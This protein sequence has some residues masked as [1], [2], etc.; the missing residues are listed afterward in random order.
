MAASWDEIR[1]LAADLQHAQLSSTVQRLSD[2]NCIEIVNK[3]VELRLLE[4]VFTCDGKEYVTPQHII[5]EIKDELLIHGGRI[6]LVDLAQLLNLDFSHIEAKAND[7]VRSDKTL[8]LVL[9]QIISRNYLD[10]IAEEINERLQQSGQISIGEL[11]KHYDLP[12]Q[13]LKDSIEERLGTSIQGKADPYDNQIIFTEIFINRLRSRILGALSAATVP[14]SVLNLVNHHNFHERF[15]HSITND[16]ISNGLLAGSIS[17][18]RQERAIYIPTIYS[19]AQ[20]EWVENFYRQNGYLEFD[21]LIR[22]GISEPVK[23]IKKIFSDQSLTYLSTCVVGQS[24]VDQ[25]DASVDEALVSGTWVD[26]MPILPTVCDSDDARQLLLKNMKDRSHRSYSGQIFCDTIVCSDKFIQEL[27]KSF[28]VL[29][30]QKAEKDAQKG[31]SLV[32]KD[33]KGGGEGLS[34]KDKKDERRKK[35]A[36][37]KSG[38]G[39]QGRETKTRAVKKKYRSR[40]SDDSDDEIQ[41]TA[42]KVKE[43]EFLSCEEIV[44]ELR[45]QNRDEDC[46][47]ELLDAIA[48]YIHRPLT[49]AYQQIV[50]S[51]FVASVA[52]TGATRRKAHVE[53]QEKV[54]GLVNNIRLFEKGLKLFPDDT[55]TQL[56]K[57]LLRTLGTDVTNLIFGYV[58]QENRLQ[59]GDDVNITSDIRGKVLINVLDEIRAPLSKL[60]TS[61]NG[62]SVEDFLTAVECASGP[63]VAFG[64]RQ[65]LLEQLSVTMD[66]A[67]CLHL[68]ALILYQ[69]MTHCMLHAS[70]KFVPQILTF[71]ESQLNSEIVEFLQM[72]QG[73]VIKLLTVGS[74]EES[75]QKIKAQLEELMPKVKEIA[76]TTKK[77]SHSEQ[78]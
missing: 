78:D 32:S 69:T 68:S 38:G 20:N 21:A 10:S 18:G 65:C 74:D 12:A 50:Q 13:F 70:G 37:G 4:V 77:T 14:I 64:H 47:D 60:N 33:V 35:A 8:S 9:G 7:L 27:V 42:N 44:V 71:L 2:R 72:Y 40:D 75:G 43:I 19:K 23:F 28:D 30:V 25:I 22:L 5:N 58:A 6:N 61:L 55:R 46:P 31:V 56:N 59:L 17:G 52:E 36:G 66:G 11:I 24:L 51:V 39:T 54:N 49:K 1:R 48:E 45:K 76:T 29:M 53:L 15:F 67:L 63:G 62:K 16:L 73:L 34:R 3:V 26:I 41:P 57:H